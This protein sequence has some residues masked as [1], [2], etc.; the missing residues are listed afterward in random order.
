[1]LFFC[2][3]KIGKPC[4]VDVSFSM[5]C[6]SLKL[7]ALI[8]IPADSPPPPALSSNVSSFP[9]YIALRP[10][11]LFTES[12]LV[13]NTKLSKLGTASSAWFSIWWKPRN[14]QV[15]TACSHNGVERELHPEARDLFPCHKWILLG[16]ALPLSWPQFIHLWNHGWCKKSRRTL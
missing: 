12:P 1:M 13:S 3:W 14:D 7:G 16:K 10:S 6:F 5:Y 9:G 4:L 8:P 15:L 2:F 11:S